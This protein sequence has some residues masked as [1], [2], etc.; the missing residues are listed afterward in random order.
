MTH[1]NGL[2][3]AS[4]TFELF[5]DVTV[6]E[7]ISDATTATNKNSMTCPACGL[8]TNSL[9]NSPEIAK[10]ICPFPET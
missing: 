9:K 8:G 3:L 1:F 7:I 6:G 5:H 4:D 2:G 10:Q